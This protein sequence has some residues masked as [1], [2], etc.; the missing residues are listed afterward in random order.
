MRAPV[1]LAV[2]FWLLTEVQLS[3]AKSNAISELGTEFLRVNSVLSLKEA[4]SVPI[5]SIPN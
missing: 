2:E 5:L 3:E 4:L 1:P